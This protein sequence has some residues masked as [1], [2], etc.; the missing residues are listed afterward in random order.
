[1][2]QLTRQLCLWA[3]LLPVL[4]SILDLMVEFDSPE[5]AKAAFDAFQEERGFARQVIQR[6]GELDASS[7]LEMSDTGKIWLLCNARRAA[8]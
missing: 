4:V 6:R 3:L 8:A 1:M 2:G 5:A 7:D